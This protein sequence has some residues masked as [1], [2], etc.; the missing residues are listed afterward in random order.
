M[1]GGPDRYF[2][3]TAFTFAPPDRYGNLGRN[4]LIGPGYTDLDFSFVK[5]TF[6]P[7]IS[8]RF[9]VSFRVEAFNL[10]NRA[11]F[12]LPAGQVY[13]GN[14][15]SIVAGRITETVASSRQVQLCLKIFW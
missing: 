1:L 14:G 7:S 15:V 6:I 4:T 2:D 10:F 3:S 5:D 11:N 9:V 12:A 8:E 13:D